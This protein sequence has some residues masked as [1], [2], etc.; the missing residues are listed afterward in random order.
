[1][2]MK[3]LISGLGV[4]KLLLFFTLHFSLFTFIACEGN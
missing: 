3:I 1:M 2:R 4:V